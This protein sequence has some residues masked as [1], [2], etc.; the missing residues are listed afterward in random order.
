M[1]AIT[2]KVS[3][4]GVTLGSYGSGAIPTSVTAK[5]YA[6]GYNASATEYVLLAEGAGTGADT[7]GVITCTGGLAAGTNA[8][9]KI[10]IYSDGSLVWSGE[11]VVTFAA[12]A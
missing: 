3:T 9:L 5:V 12:D 11:K 7:A 6:K 2:P 1:T 4:V 8:T 10:E